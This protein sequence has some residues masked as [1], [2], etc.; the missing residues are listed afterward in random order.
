MRAHIRAIQHRRCGLAAHCSVALSVLA[1]D[2][3]PA[4]A[5]E[6]TVESSRCGTQQCA[7]KDR[8]FGVVRCCA[9]YGCGDAGRESGR[10]GQQEGGDGVLATSV[11]DDG[12]FDG[13]WLRI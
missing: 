11:G 2:R 13:L 9:I 5:A 1:W 7:A 6:L 10:A 12:R 8:A 4:S 3:V